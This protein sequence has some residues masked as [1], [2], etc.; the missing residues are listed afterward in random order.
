MTWWDS[1]ADH[2]YIILKYPDINCRVYLYSVSAS[3]KDL[4]YITLD[5]VKTNY[6]NMDRGKLNKLKE[7]LAYCRSSSMIIKF[8]HSPWQCRFSHK[9]S[10]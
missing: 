2:K 10:G 3:R 7:D 9:E 5:E 8:Q 4:C 1:T 6:T